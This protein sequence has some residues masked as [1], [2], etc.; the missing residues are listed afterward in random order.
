MGYKL[1]KLYENRARD[2]PLW[3]VYIPNFDQIPVKISHQSVQRVAT[4]GRKDV[5]IGL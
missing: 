5:K 2:T 3:G 1:C 4:A